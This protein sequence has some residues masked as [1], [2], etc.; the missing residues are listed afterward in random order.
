MGFINWL[1]R[2]Q[3][4]FSFLTITI[5]ILLLLTT[6]VLWLTL[7]E[8]IEVIDNETTQETSSSTS[9][10]PT[11]S[12]TTI[13]I[14]TVSTSISTTPSTTTKTT[15]TSTTTTTTLIN[16]E[17]LFLN[18]KQIFELP[19]F[20]PYTCSNLELPSAISSKLFGSVGIVFDQQGT[21]RLLVGGFK[22]SST[23][24]SGIWYKRTENGWEEVDK[25]THYREF[26][27]SSYLESS[28]ESWIVT[29]QGCKELMIL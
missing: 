23:S 9:S 8:N 24:D 10:I 20:S 7:S 3:K 13:S 22:E 5:I 26:S 14:S 2:K 1:N 19:S 17:V 28:K 6:L 25:S 21:E 4:I 18:E 27:A 29:G 15:T 12:T 16:N 11:L